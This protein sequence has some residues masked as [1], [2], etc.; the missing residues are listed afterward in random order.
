MSR[1]DAALHL[2]H[3][4]RLPNIKYQC[5]KAQATSPT[6]TVA[7]ATV[8]GSRGLSLIAAIRPHAT[9]DIS[10]TLTTQDMIQR[11]KASR[12]ASLMPA[13]LAVE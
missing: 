11:L 2:E 3:C 10:P 6:E 1:A 8:P 13:I 12:G 4:H 9:T 7:N 5:T